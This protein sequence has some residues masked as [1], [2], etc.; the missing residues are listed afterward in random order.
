[1]NAQDYLEI[2][3]DL[4]EV[5]WDIKDANDTHTYFSDDRLDEL[6][7]LYSKCE[8]F[9]MEFKKYHKLRGRE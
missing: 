6:K 1:M 8:M 5:V 7:K 4:R 9:I 2:A 3:E